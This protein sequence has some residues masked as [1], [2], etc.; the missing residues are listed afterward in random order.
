M[1][2]HFARDLVIQARHIRIA[3]LVSRRNTDKRRAYDAGAHAG[4]ALLLGGL[5]RNDADDDAGLLLAEKLVI[6]DRSF[7]GY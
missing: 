4:G 1:V 6:H 7:D 3:A 5:G 2:L